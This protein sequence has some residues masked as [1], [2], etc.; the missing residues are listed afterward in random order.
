[1]KEAYALLKENRFFSLG[2][3]AELGGGGGTYDALCQTV[4]ELAHHDGSTALAF[5]MH[6]HLL[7]ATVWKHRRG[8]PGEALLRRIADGE[9]VLLSTGASD[10]VD[11]NGEMK[12]VDGG[13]RVNARKIFGSGSPAADIMITTARYDDPEH[14]P[15]VLHFPV[16]MTADGVSSREDWDTLGM[17]G[18]ASH[19]LELRDVFVSDEAIALRR[20]AGQWHPAWS[21]VITL[22]PPIYMAAYVGIAEAAAELALAAARKRGDSQHAPYLAGELANELQATRTHW[23]RMVAN[24][25]GYDFS[26]SLALAS[27]ALAGKTLVAKH[28]IAT[29][30]KAMELAGG[31][32]YFKSFG[33]ERLL[34]DVHGAPYHALPE[35]RQ[36]H[37]SGR[38]ALGLDPITGEPLA[39]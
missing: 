2:V 19:T 25:N 33:L 15:Q 37:F 1:M 9:R 29:V 13:F 6:A 4:R 31:A 22:A 39:G 35:K 7:A 30:H 12:K 3:P 18:T 21:V 36:L 23:A 16:P 8:Q 10:W 11:S 26:P 38:I 32:G 20:P 34:R 27:D 17:R 14:G 28:A 24:V 5:S